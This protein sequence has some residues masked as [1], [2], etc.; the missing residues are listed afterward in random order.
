[1]QTLGCS[2]QTGPASLSL[3]PWKHQ[4]VANSGVLVREAD[5]ACCRP[6]QSVLV[7]IFHA[8]PVEGQDFV[9]NELI[10]KALEMAQEGSLKGAVH[11]IKQFQGLLVASF[12]L[13][14]KAMEH[15]LWILREHGTI[16]KLADFTIQ[17]VRDLALSIH[18]RD[19]SL[20]DPSYVEDMVPLVLGAAGSVCSSFS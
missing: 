7:K 17:A 20:A 6:A 8:Y 1:M 4:E 16:P 15:C 5:H 2:C 11:T 9:L 13:A 14:Q 12:P 10:P 18:P 3:P 19:A